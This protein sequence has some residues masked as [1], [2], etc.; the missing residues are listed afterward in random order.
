MKSLTRY[1]KDLQAKNKKALVTYVTAGMPKWIECI[2]ACIDSGADIVE[3]GLPFSDPIMDG[4]VISR[5]SAYALS[6]GAQTL[7]LLDEL[8]QQ[9]FAA[10]LAVMTYANVLYSHSIDKIIPQIEQC[11]V[12]GLIVP[13]VTFEQRDLIASCTDS[14]DVALIPLVSSTTLDSRRADIIESAEGFL[15]CVAIKGI[16]GES[17]VIDRDFISEV[18]DQSALPAYCGVGVRSAAD[19][20]SIVDVCEGVIVGTSV[21]EK[22]FEDKSVELIGEFVS[23]LRNAIDEG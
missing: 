20:Q 18:A 3:V 11:G 22:M 9:E 13:D 23:I 5:A 12:S 2:H 1:T 19:A 16:T 17:H 8:E 6:H 10:P 15:Y 7:K 21:V 14:T 4:P